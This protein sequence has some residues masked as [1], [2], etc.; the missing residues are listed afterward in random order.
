MSPGAEG[1]G[2]PHLVLNVRV[3]L[4]DKQWVNWASVI[5][6]QEYLLE[7]TEKEHFSK[8]HCEVWSRPLRMSLVLGQVVEEEP[9]TFSVVIVSLPHWIQTTR[10]KI[11]ALAQNMGT[12]KVCSSSPMRQLKRPAE[13]FALGYVWED[14]NPPNQPKIT[15]T[16]PGPPKQPKITKSTPGPPNVVPGPPQICFQTLKNNE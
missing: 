10:E 3:C 1:F 7:R 9:G 16:T 2:S 8:A 5:F 15:K 14:R 4:M 13:L 12:F 6:S 11:K